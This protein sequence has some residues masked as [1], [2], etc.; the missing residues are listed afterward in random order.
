MWAIML[1]NFNRCLGEDIPNSCRSRGT[2][3]ETPELYSLKGDGK[4]VW[5][6]P[7]NKRIRFKRLY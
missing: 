1:N 3:W 5:P 4:R 7:Y 2:I 6:A